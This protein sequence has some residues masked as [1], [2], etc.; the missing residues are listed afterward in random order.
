M[1]FRNIDA[2]SRMRG[3][4]R[5]ERGAGESDAAVESVDAFRQCGHFLIA[6]IGRNLASAEHRHPL[7]SGPRERMVGRLP[8]FPPLA[9]SPIPALLGEIESFL[10]AGVIEWAHPRSFDGTRRTASPPAILGELLGAALG[11]PQ[12]KGADDS[13]L[14]ELS[15]LTMNWVRQ[16]IGLP[17]ATEAFPCAERW[18]GT[19]LALEAARSAAKDPTS[20]FFVPGN[21]RHLTIFA[22]ELAPCFLETILPASSG[23]TV[24]VRRLPV[25]ESL[26]VRGEALVASIA[27]LDEDQPGQCVVIGGAGGAAGACD[28]LLEFA[29]VCSRHRL[30]FH[31]DAFDGGGAC[32]VPEI[33]A[34]LIGLER[35][36]SVLVEPARWFGTRGP[37]T[38]LF[39]RRGKHVKRGLD[40]IRGGPAVGPPI[41]SRAIEPADVPNPFSLWFV[42]RAL[43]W[44]GLAESVRER[45]R[46]AK[47]MAS[48]IDASDSFE[49]TGP[50]LLDTVCFRAR[51]ADLSLDELDELNADLV[52]RLDEE[53]DIATGMSTLHGRRVLC[54][55][56]NDAQTREPDVRRAWAVMRQALRDVLA[57]RRGPSSEP[58]PGLRV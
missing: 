31:V 54:F 17:D 57:D 11:G 44:D 14:S 12:L 22:S 50:V 7:A 15:L 16:L 9:P 40:V 53:M 39:S 35:A 55:T 45:V 18:K 43:G 46:L 47:L 1:T 25:D 6:W 24:R 30:W 8:S 41:L 21:G 29:H 23:V 33:R 10:N 58:P 52:E 4:A 48:W 32:I 49:R 51:V 3:P 37:S 26:A 42:L 28:A 5:L 13:F 38:I 34:S 20:P 27:S 2:P 56:V 36:D 19:Y